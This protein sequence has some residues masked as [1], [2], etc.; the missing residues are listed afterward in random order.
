MAAIFCAQPEFQAFLDAKWRDDAPYNTA[1]KA[2]DLVRRVC[3]VDSRAQF[4]NDAAAAERF[5]DR[6]RI[7]YVNWQLGLGR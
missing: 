4:D 6:V 1:E 3:E 5:H 2:A 7:P